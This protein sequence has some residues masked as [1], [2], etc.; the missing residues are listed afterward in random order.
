MLEFPNSMSD[1]G[2]VEAVIMGLNE[3]L[4]KKDSEMGSLTQRMVNC[5]LETEED[6]DKLIRFLIDCYN[7]D[8]YKLRHFV[9]DVIKTVVN[10]MINKKQKYNL[11][12]K[13]KSR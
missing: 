13:E 3:I 4:E 11:I 7:R 10:V 5:L 1:A 12:L 6:L 2:T 8:L 9:S